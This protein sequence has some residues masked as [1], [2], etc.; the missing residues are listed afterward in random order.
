MD[1]LRAAAVCV[2]GL[3]AAGMG[4]VLCQTLM[5]AIPS[6]DTKTVLMKVSPSFH[7]G[8]QTDVWFDAVPAAFH[9]AKRTTLG[10]LGGAQAI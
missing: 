9:V 1:V 6:Q 7:S 4:A 2:P 10:G 8:W 5:N 3:K